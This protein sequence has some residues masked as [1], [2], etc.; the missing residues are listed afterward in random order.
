[1]TSKPIAITFA[2][3]TFAG[4]GGCAGDREFAAGPRQNTELSVA[5][6]PAVAPGPS[7]AGPR[8]NA[9][10]V[11]GAVGG[12]VVGSQ[13]G[14]SPGTRV[15]AGVAGAAIGGLIGNRIGAAMDDEDR[16]RAYAAQ[17]DALESGPGAA[18]VTWRNPDS[19]RNGSI[20]PGPVSQRG[21]MQCRQ[22]THTI[23]LD[24]QP[25]V[26]RGTACRN[27]DGSW[28]SVG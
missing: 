5:A 20:V 9:G 3:L 11:V 14:G 19:G 8:E 28:K 23:Y 25:Q 1:M 27:P 2:V 18:P 4:L 10:T 22:Y 26:A 13:I 16:Q 24:G 12:A 7:M 6:E 21:G 15:A 17:V